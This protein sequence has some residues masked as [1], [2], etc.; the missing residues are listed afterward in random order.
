MSEE[1]HKELF[2][3][4]MA[5]MTEIP[6][7]EGAPQSIPAMEASR[8]LNRLLESA[9]RMGGDEGKNNEENNADGDREMGGEWRLDTARKL[10]GVSSL[11]CCLAA[12]FVVNSDFVHILCTTI[13]N[14]QMKSILHNHNMLHTTN[15]P[16]CSL[17]NSTPCKMN[18][19]P[20]NPTTTPPT[21]SSQP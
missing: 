12:P 13:F 20:T 1:T 19:T 8:E 5:E 18:L 15:S 3:R 10:G 4:E 6:T 7:A 14:E 16:S 9:L 21:P 2:A 17:P 11:D